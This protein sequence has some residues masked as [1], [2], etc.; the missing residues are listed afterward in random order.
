GLPSIT[1]YRLEVRE[2]TANKQIYKRSSEIFKDEMHCRIQYLIGKLILEEF[3]YVESPL[4]WWIKREKI[5]TTISWEKHMQG[6][7]NITPYIGVG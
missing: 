4:G 7:T 1:L 6:W 5:N 2:R 3:G